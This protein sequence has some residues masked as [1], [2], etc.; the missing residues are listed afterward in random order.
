MD[1]H[2]LGHIGHLECLEV[3]E[4]RALTEE[5]VPMP[6]HVSRVRAGVSWEPSIAETLHR[7]SLKD[8]EG[9]QRHWPVRR[10]LYHPRHDIV[11]QNS[12]LLCPGTNSH[13][14]LL[15]VLIE[16]PLQVH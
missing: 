5:L 2:E 10:L 7:L 9:R 15:V 8:L 13:D 14:F 3:S 12:V 16:R 4:G 1:V 11:G 6:R